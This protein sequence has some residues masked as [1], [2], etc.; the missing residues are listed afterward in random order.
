MSIGLVW[1]A[2]RAKD[3]ADAANENSATLPSLVG[4]YLKGIAMYLAAYRSREELT[5]NEMA[6]KLSLSLNRYREYE[7]N[8]TDNSKGISLDL[9]LKIAGLEGF[10]LPHFLTKIGEETPDVPVTLPASR[11]D[12]LEV[13]LLSEWRHVP[14]DDRLTFVR[15]HQQLPQPDSDSERDSEPL[16]PQRMRWTI[17]VAN[18]LG[19]LPYEIRMKFEREV[20]EEYMDVMRPAA[21]SAEHASLLERLR[22]LIKQY[23]TNFDGSKR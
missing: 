7:Q 8:T 10:Q 11:V 19:K 4:D 2:R 9:L 3:L 23:Y 15:L 6:Q 20:I 14:S 13:A 22:E 12:L 1:C 18:L 5:Q 21:D 17:R 16:I